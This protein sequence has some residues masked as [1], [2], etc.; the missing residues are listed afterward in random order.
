MSEPSAIETGRDGA[1]SSALAG[2]WLVNIDGDE[3]VEMTRVQ[4][5]AS[6]GSGRIQEHTLVWHEGMDDWAPL[7]QVPAF[8]LLSLRESTIPESGA[9]VKT[10]SRPP[11]KPARRAVT[12]VGLAPP[13]SSPV[14]P[15]VAAGSRPYGDS[16]GSSDSVTLSR[17]ALELLGRDVLEI[18]EREALEVQQSSDSVTVARAVLEPNL[19]PQPRSADDT[20]VLAVYDRPIATIE[21]PEVG[22]ESTASAKLDDDPTQMRAPIV[23][24]A[25]PA[26]PVRKLTPV[27]FPPPPPG[28]A[29]TRG[30]SPL[31]AP[32]TS[33]ATRSTA[34]SPRQ[35]GAAP[36]FASTIRPAAGTPAVIGGTLAPAPERRPP[37]RNPPPAPLDSRGSVA[38]VAATANVPGSVAP[39]AATANVRG[40]VARQ[41]PASAAPHVL[42]PTPVAFAAH[43]APRAT[44]APPAGARPVAAVPAS[45]PP[46]APVL[47]STATAPITTAAPIAAVAPKAKLPTALAPA[48]AAA[49]SAPTAPAFRAAPLPSL[50]E[51]DAAALRGGRR[52]P[53]FWAVGGCLASAAIASLVTAMV[54]GKPAAT[55]VAAAPVAT[56]EPAKVAPPPPPPATV[57]PAATEEPAPAAPEVAPK[58]AATV[59]APA[60]VEKPKKAA[61]AWK[62]KPKAKVVVSDSPYE[63][64]ADTATAPVAA[65]PPAPSPSP[66]WQGDPSGLDKPASA[67]AIPASGTPA[68]AATFNPGF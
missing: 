31:P 66:S 62:P 17:E 20:S 48:A 14:P 23:S 16:E 39:A 12:E 7:V 38:L 63:T 10:R 32:I 52:V 2:G 30:R 60:P 49:L 65:T 34:P 51:L 5:V 33:P 40:P 61:T 41:E 56:L 29:E 64:P 42:G 46:A 44:A 53:L 67:E 22:E 9:R 25:P 58:A 55:S 59:A 1:E 6:F 18:A 43:A 15:L 50:S 54:T 19:E 3:I 27:A 57:T 37:M 4:V 11:P 26:A 13:P 24:S 45:V 68:P 8:R 36:R 35:P 47:P 21:F 28:P